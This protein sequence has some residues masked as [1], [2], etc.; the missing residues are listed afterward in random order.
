LEL[1]RPENAF[2]AE[3]QHLFRSR[4][5]NFTS[6]AGYFD[7]DGRIDTTL[8]F[9]IPPPDGPGPFEVSESVS[10]DLQHVNVY[11]YAHLHLLKNVMFTVGLSADFL[12]GDS[13]DVGDQD[14]FNPKFGITWNPFPATTIRAAVFR[15]LKRTL[16]TDQ[17]LEPTQVAGFNQFFDDINGTE[18]WR[19][20][21]AIDQ[22]FTKD[23]FGGVEFSKRDLNVPFLDFGDL[24]NPIAREEDMDEYLGRAYLFWTPHR[25]LALRAEY[26]FERLKSEGLTDQPIDLTTHRMPLGVSFFHPSGLS[27]SL[28]TTY[29]NQ[30]GDFITQSGSDDFWIVDMAVNYRLP[31]RYGVM[32]VGATN[33][34]D[35]DF[36]FFDRD[37][38]NPSIQPD[39][40]FFARV[41]L[42]LP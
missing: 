31:K 30:D 13:L 26:L 6:G 22:K 28:R 3:I 36:K 11:A 29:F 10:T 9:D 33:L 12:S 1:K 32:T 25:W 5:F 35:Q 4:Y 34:F 20:G 39:R 2:G 27:A 18:S 19:Y 24:G 37:F 41:T 40:M 38:G 42:A 16:I 7:I 21:G 23:I 8:G 14:Q 17:T 15:V